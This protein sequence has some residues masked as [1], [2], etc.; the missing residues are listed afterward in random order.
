M[1]ASIL[2]LFILTTFTQRMLIGIPSTANIILGTHTSSISSHVIPRFTCPLAVLNYLLLTRLLS[3][4]FNGTVLAY[5]PYTQAQTI[6]TFPSITNNTDYRIGG[7][8]FS[9]FTSSIFIGAAASLPFFTSGANRTGNNKLIRYDTSTNS[10]IY[11]VD[12]KTVQDAIYNQTGQQVNGF[13]DMVEDAQGN[14]YFI[15]SFGG[16]VVK[17]DSDG[18]VGQFYTPPTPF[19]AS[20]ILYTRIAYVARGNKLVGG[21]PRL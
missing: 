4:D 12:L 2:L 6:L 7:I 13:Q 11:I 15:A 3:A 10:T 16:V 8:D 17:I 14:A 5:D 21:P 19:D 1:Q 20:A 18:N 9:P